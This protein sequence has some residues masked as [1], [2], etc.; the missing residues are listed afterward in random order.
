MKKKSYL[1]VDK[2]GRTPE[3]KSFIP[4]MAPDEPEDKNA[5]KGGIENR[6]LQYVLEQ[7]G[8]A[9]VVCDASGNILRT[10]RVVYRSC[11]HPRVQQPFHEIFHLSFSTNRRER[12]SAISFPNLSK[13]FFAQVLNGETF[14]HEKVQ[15]EK[16]DGTIVPVLFSASPIKDED[17]KILGGIVTLVDSDSRNRTDRILQRH[18]EVLEHIINDHP[19]SIILKNL[20]LEVEHHFGPGI[21]ASILLLNEEGCQ[22]RH[23]AGPSLAE[24]Y[25][26]AVDGISDGYR[27]AGGH[28]HR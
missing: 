4:A 27:L 3:L 16:Q 28:C 19:L 13:K 6:L 22:L 8:E 11:Q 23:G 25:K 12:P 21:L 1:P 10:N 9:L 14:R 7:T 15:L 18:N 5:K 20:C 24:N 2:F 17:Q 26:Q